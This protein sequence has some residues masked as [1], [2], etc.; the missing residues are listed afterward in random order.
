[1]EIYLDLSVEIAMIE[2]MSIEVL[3]GA[4][5]MHESLPGKAYI[6]TIHGK[7]MEQEA[8]KITHDVEEEQ[9]ENFRDSQK[10]SHSREPRK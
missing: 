7:K 9:K 1:M 2:F 4:L 8:E 6:R 3:T 10:S 5:R